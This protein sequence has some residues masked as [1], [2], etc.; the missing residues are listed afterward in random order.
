[1]LRFAIAALL[2][3]PC[4]FPQA[5]RIADYTIAARLNVADRSVEGRERISWLNDSSESAGELRFHL[6][7]NAFKNTKSTFLRE[8]GGQLRGERMD[9]DS[10]GYIDIQRMQVAGGADLTKSIQF[11][12]PDDGNADDRTVVRVPLPKPVGPGDRIEL[13]IEF[14]T[15]FPHVFARAGFHGSFFLGGQWF[16]KI[17]VWEKAGTRYATAGAVE[18]PSV[19]R[20]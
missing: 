11:I 17:G 8:S 5:K 16:P 2:L 18:L 10:W 4:A 13:D 20:Q 1:M 19:P 3:P 12:A 15:R 14:H 7:M 9:K 6:Y